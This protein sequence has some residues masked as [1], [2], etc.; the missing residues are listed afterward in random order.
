ME[1]L[2]K[3]ILPA[4]VFIS[5]FMPNAAE[6][7]LWKGAE[8][9]ASGNRVSGNEFI[10][11]FASLIRKYQNRATLFYAKKMG[12][13]TLELSVTIKALS[14]ITANE[15]IIEYLTLEACDLLENTDKSISEIGEYLNF[16][17][18]VFSRFFIRNKKCTASEWRMLNQ[19]KR[20]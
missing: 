10:D 19:R 7:E 18:S 15:W 8:I 4:D 11:F 1:A 17:Q 14:G 3:K 9:N 13:K 20:K 6:I 12:L 16:R 2:P 5:A